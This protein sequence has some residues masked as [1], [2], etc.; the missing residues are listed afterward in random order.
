MYVLV[1]K[2]PHNST[3][4]EK[5]LEFQP[6]YIAAQESIQTPCCWSI[7][8]CASLER[9]VVLYMSGVKTF[10]QL[11]LTRSDHANRENCCKSVNKIFE[12]CEGILFSYTCR[13]EL[14]GVPKHPGSQFSG[15]CIFGFFNVLVLG[16]CTD[17]I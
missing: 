1:R 10:K 5:I 8:I 14:R 9:N 13:S 2:R 15:A 17:A 16:P 6:L 11:L 3:R 7:C 4:P 12:Y